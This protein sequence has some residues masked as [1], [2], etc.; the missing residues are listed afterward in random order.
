MVAVLAV[1]SLISLQQRS[2]NVALM[3]SIH[4]GDVGGVKQ[5]LDQGA[6]LEV[7]VAGK[8]PLSEAVRCGDWPV[9]H[10]LI[11]AQSD[12]RRYAE[13]VLPLAVEH[14]APALVLRV[15]REFGVKSDGGPLG[16]RRAVSENKVGVFRAFVEIGAKPTRDQLGNPLIF[17]ACRASTQMLSGVVSSFGQTKEL[18]PYGESAL[19]HAADAS[20]DNVLFLLGAGLKADALDRRGRSV[21]FYMNPRS[22][23]AARA[24]LVFEHGADPLRPDS[25]GETAINWFRKKGD[26]EMVQIL[27][28][29]EGGHSGIRH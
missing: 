9:V 17:D 5:A 14:D 16:M 6:S 4:S 19:F 24:R 20:R 22:G 2:A 25:S 21:F 3:R 7:V 27:R 26:R 11:S 18:G 15:G 8:L 13:L 10:T 1:L 29:L 23:R 28:A 12:P